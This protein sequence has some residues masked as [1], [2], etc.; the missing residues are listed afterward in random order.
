MKP[1]G[2]DITY[3]GPGQVTMYP[4]FPLEWYWRDLHRYMRTLEE[5]CIN[6]LKRYNLNGERI[7]GLTGVWIGNEKIAAIGIAVSGWVTYYGMAVNI[8]P[9]MEHF[10]LIRPCGI[11]NKGVTSLTRLTGKDY[12]ISEEMD[13]LGEEFC[14]TFGNAELIDSD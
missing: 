10:S 5:T 11:E 6:Y 4:V 14:N 12:N 8:C 13:K 1:E 2:G 9:E 7:K 3:H